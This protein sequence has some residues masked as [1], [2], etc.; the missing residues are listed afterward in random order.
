MT[1]LASTVSCALWLAVCPVVLWSGRAGAPPPLGGFPAD[2]LPH[3]RAPPN[4]RLIAFGHPVPRLDEIGA[5]LVVDGTVTAIDV[6]AFG[7]D[8]LTLTPRTPL[9]AGAR[10]VVTVGAGGNDV[11][12]VFVVDAAADVVPPVLT[13]AAVIDDSSGLVIGVE[14][15]DDVALTGFVARADGAVVGATAPGF[16]LLA[17]VDTC[18]DVTALDAAGL[19]SAATRLCPGEGEGEEGEGEEGEGEEGEGEGGGEGEGEGGGE[20]CASQTASSSSAAALSL[21]LAL[22]RFRTRTR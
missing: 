22:V 13:V 2:V 19:E 3:D 11:E 21:L 5:S 8:A 10:G 4:L 20:G 12:S 9:S 16:V 15:S 7:P 14:G 1:R 18:V 6:A 17:A